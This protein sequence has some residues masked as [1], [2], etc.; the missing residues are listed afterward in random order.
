MGRNA[1]SPMAMPNAHM[2]GLGRSAGEAILE[3]A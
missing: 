2:G 1:K 3:F